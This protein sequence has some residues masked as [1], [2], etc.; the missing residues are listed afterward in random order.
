MLRT[1]Y[2]LIDH[3]KSRNYNPLR[4]WIH[5]CIIGKTQ[6]YK[7]VRYHAK[8]RGNREKRDFCQ[9]K[10]IAYEKPTDQFLEE[11]ANGKCA[12]GVANIIR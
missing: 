11:I 3:A 6:R 4:L 7:G 12:P 10:I 8:G 2:N 1:F 9:V 5:G